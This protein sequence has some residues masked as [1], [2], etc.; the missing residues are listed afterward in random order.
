MEPKPLVLTYKRV[1]SRRDTD[2]IVWD[3]DSESIFNLK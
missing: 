3:P 1:F 2:A